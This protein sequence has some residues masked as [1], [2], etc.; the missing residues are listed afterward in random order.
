MVWWES[1]DA[2][3]RVLVEVERL[4]FDKQNPRFTPEKRPTSDSDAAFIG[5]L[6]ASADLGELIESIS[7]SGYVDIEP[8]IVYGRGD[9]LVVIEGNRRLAALKAL[10]DPALAREARLSVP[11]I[12]PEISAT[13]DKVSV[14]RV[15]S[16]IEARTLIGFK[17]INGPQAWD[18]HAKGIY[19][20]RW[21]D[22]ERIKREAG[23]HGLTVSEIAKSMGDK[24]D[25]IHRLITA[26]Y[27]LEQAESKQIWTVGDRSVKNFSFSHLYTALTYNEYREF[28][29]MP[30][31][32]RSLDPV[33]DPVPETHFWALKK[34]LHWLFG[35]RSENVEPSIKKQNPDIARLKKVLANPISLRVMLETGDL[36]VAEVS[37]IPTDARFEMHL[38]DADQSLRNALSFLDGFDGTD[39]TLLAISH[40]VFSKARTI[41]QS[42][43]MTSR[44]FDAQEDLFGGADLGPERT[45]REKK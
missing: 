22:D 21:L 13:F 17:H 23:V 6:A 39:Q 42:M 19:A 37:S 15:V 32:D 44:S 25:T 8:L 43:T 40:Q 14:Y 12:P 11:T 9:E 34:V 7:T 27:V 30:P 20:A 5:Q 4:S 24:N 28:V 36:E 3:S 38:V 2:R 41:Y 1:I 10:R 31:Q 26:I 18:A 45:E 33:R 29:G 16:E 35:Q